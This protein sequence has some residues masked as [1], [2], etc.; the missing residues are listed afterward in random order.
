LA[1]RA[2]TDEVLKKLHLLR[3]FDPAS[4]TGASVPDPYY[5]GGRGFEE[6]LDL[7]FAGCRGLL[8][9]II[10]QHRLAVS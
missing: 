5:G 3:S 6:V 7:C 9:Q 1:E 2:P 4:P 10:A 8:A